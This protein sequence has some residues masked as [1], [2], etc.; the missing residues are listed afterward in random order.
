MKTILNDKKFVKLGLVD[1]SK[2]TCSSCSKTKY[3]LLIFM[4]LSGQLFIYSPNWTS[5]PRTIKK[6]F[7]YNLF[8]LQWVM[9]NVNWQNVW[10][11]Y[12][13]QYLKCIYVTTLRIL[14]HLLIL[15]RIVC[16][17][18]INVCALDSSI[19]LTCILNEVIDICTDLLYCSNLSP[20]CIPAANLGS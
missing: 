20:P 12:F 16:S 14:F 7:L 4:R 19:V 11:G 9:F 15:C 10:L 18:L 3:F 13:N 2:N 6:M 8:C 5:Y 17:D 1:T